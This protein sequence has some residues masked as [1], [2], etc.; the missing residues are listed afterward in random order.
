MLQNS[1]NVGFPRCPLIVLA[2]VDVDYPTGSCRHSTLTQYSIHLK[3]DYPT[4]MHLP[5]KRQ[6]QI[7]AVWLKYVYITNY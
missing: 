2:L 7:K 1:G 4:K 6:K 5:H 3:K